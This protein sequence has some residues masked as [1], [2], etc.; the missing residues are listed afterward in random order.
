MPLI[1]KVRG[2]FP[3][4]NKARGDK[5]TVI[6]PDDFGWLAQQFAV[7]G[8]N[9]LY[10][11][12]G[13]A[14]RWDV[15]DDTIV[16][17]S[18]NI[19]IQH[20]Y[21]QT[22]YLWTDATGWNLYKD[23]PT[24]YKP[25]SIPHPFYCNPTASS[26]LVPKPLAWWTLGVEIQENT[27][28]LGVRKFATSP[29][30]AASA[31]PWPASDVDSVTNA[32]DTGI[33]TRNMFSNIFGI[34]GTADPIG[35]YDP[36]RLEET[37]YANG[38]T[39]AG[40]AVAPAWRVDFQIKPNGTYG[41]EGKAIDGAGY[42]AAV[43]KNLRYWSDKNGDENAASFEDVE[44]Q[45]SPFYSRNVPALAP[46]QLGVG[47][48]HSETS[49]NTASYLNP[50]AYQL[51]DLAAQ[52]QTD[53]KRGRN[54]ACADYFD[55]STPVWRTTPGAAATT[56]PDPAPAPDLAATYADE[57]GEAQVQLRPGVGFYFDNL[58]LKPNS[59]HGCD[60]Q[61]ID[62]LGISEV[63]ATVY[64]PDQSP[65]LPQLQ[66]N[67]IKQVWYNGFNA[68]LA[69]TPKGGYDPGWRV[70][71]WKTDVTGAASTTHDEI[72]CLSVLDGGQATITQLVE[73]SPDAPIIEQTQ[74]TEVAGTNQGPNVICANM[75]KQPGAKVASAS[76]NVSGI[77]PL[78]VQANFVK[79]HVKRKIA[80]PTE[81]SSGGTPPPVVGYGKAIKA[82]TI[83]GKSADH[84]T[85][86]DRPTKPHATK[87]KDVKYKKIKK[88]GRT[89]RG[90]VLLRV[91]SDADKVRIKIELM[92]LDKK[93]NWVVLRT[94]KETIS[95]NTQKYVRAA[96]VKPRRLANRVLRVEVTILDGGNTG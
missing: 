82:R 17:S 47:T 43:D 19:E 1:A 4:G 70:T 40:D 32:A 24:G 18:A 84:A 2:S 80:I 90:V 67:A 49:S 42:L 60:L 56:P 15:H 21:C 93:G 58:G 51:W 29:F 81:K 61:Y 9:Q 7:D 68:K 88:Y 27:E 14:Y 34:L 37:Y 48:T 26:R 74:A 31:V 5:A 92:G 8:A 33:L 16:N 77:A 78:Q 55:G 94:R 79:E 75:V 11:G 62:T 13:A 41:E 53:V 39:D 95:A 64:Y 46:T 28:D 91:H 25:T 57:H 63:V 50:G 20:P 89:K 3:L 22:T 72:V 52:W 6:L 45:T 69:F 54:T 96:I 59:H 71:V 85:T 87:V 44:E 83:S 76:F 73:L 38:V 65:V 86:P 36:F 30:A 10:P 66:S 23:P 12:I 35:P